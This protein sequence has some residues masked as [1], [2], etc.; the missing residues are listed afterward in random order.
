MGTFA[1]GIKKVVSRYRRRFPSVQ[2]FNMD[3]T[4][5]RTK[6]HEQK[7]HAMIRR[8][9]VLHPVFYAV[10]ASISRS[11]SSGD[12]AEAIE[13]DG[14]SGRGYASIAAAIQAARQ[15]ASSGDMILITGSHYIV[16]EALSVLKTTS[17]KNKT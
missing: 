11:L 3:E 5:V 10:E 6:A 13:S 4:T 17:P 12:L 1:Q 14:G 8:F 2:P 16:G 7:H 15:A 9:G